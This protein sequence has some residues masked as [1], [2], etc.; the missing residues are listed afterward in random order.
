MRGAD[1]VNFHDPEKLI[2]LDGLRGLAA[3]M[4]LIGH[5]KWLLQE[6]Y[7]EGYLL[8]PNQYGLID[9]LGLYFFRLFRFGHEAVM[10]FFV[11][12]GFV[13]H[14]SYAQK[15][16]DGKP[17]GTID[18]INYY[19]KRISRIYPPYLVALVL[20]F[21][22]DSIGAN[23]F[24]LLYL[25]STMY[26]SINQAVSFFH[27]LRILIG[28]FFLVLEPTVV[29]FGSNS[30]TW[31]LKYE[32]WFYM[33]YPFFLVISVK[34]TW[35][36]YFLVFVLWLLSFTIGIW[37]LLMAQ[38]ICSLLICWWLGA[39]LADVYSSRIKLR[40]QHLAFL[41]ISIIVVPFISNS[42]VY[43]FLVSLSFFGVLA[44]LLSLK[45]S[46]KILT[47]LSWWGGIGKFSYTIYIIH[48]PILVFISA[49]IMETSGALPIHSG[50]VIL[51]I[52]AVIII[53]YALS[54]V[55]EQPF[56]KR[57]SV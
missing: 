57:K 45:P 40:L 21:F 20:T 4:V 29:N 15:I 50:F 43:D 10:F 5:A 32:W 22:L 3:L 36:C 2:F 37:P 52:L 30:V 1:K 53:S 28:N 11:L 39:L 6:G 41:M 25:H 17:L 38:Q 51:G 19:K 54:L 13:I 23:I 56:L 47:T 44:L 27:D 9:K 12:S 35:I 46:N 31:S 26:P 48:F 33:I 7:S 8:H 16:R 24:P 14:L 18:Y 42:I 49:W 55:V 34:R